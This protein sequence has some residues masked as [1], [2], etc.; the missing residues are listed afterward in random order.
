MSRTK[1][2]NQIVKK[3]PLKPHGLLKHAPRVGK[4]RILCKIIEKNN[5]KKVL[6]VTLSTKL[7][8][9]DIPQEVKKWIGEDWLSKMEIICYPSLANL[10]GEYD[11]II[12]DEY[13][14][15]T[16]LNTQN[17]LNGK[18]KYGYILGATGTHPKHYE[19][20]QILI[21]LG[22]GGLDSISIDEAVDM[23]L[24]APYKIITVPIKL[25]SVDRNVLA[26]SK[27]KPFYQTEKA[28][29]DYLTKVINK[30]DEEGENSL[31]MRIKRR[32]FI[33]E[34]KSKIEGAKQLLKTLQGR[35]IIFSA[36][37]KLSENYSKHTYNSKT[38]D[39]HLKEFL[40]GNLKVLS[41]VNKGGTGYTYEGVDNFIITQ[42]DTDKKGNT[43]Q[44]I[45]RSLLKQKDYVA[46]IYVIY[47]KDTVD[48][49]W[50][51]KALKGFDPSKIEKWN[52]DEF[53]N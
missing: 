46:N 8:D 23:E 26:G 48:E 31:F 2:Q 25:N 21:A 1:I 3:L 4:T 37:T 33:S 14:E 15:I 20:R 43:T 32:N 36:N 6:W 38:D 22:L 10:E 30:L 27:S 28:N 49:E 11:M 45:T 24:I 53:R 7:R 39:T 35:T 51:E 29:Y 13:Q 47:I 40:D 5:P 34:A 42:V 12:L 17:L 44:K 41:L 50:M 19:K 52:E 18:I 16:S 9:E